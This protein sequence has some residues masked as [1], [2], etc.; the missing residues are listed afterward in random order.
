MFS[1]YDSF[2]GIERSST[3]LPKLGFIQTGFESEEKPR[4]NV[5]GEKNSSYSGINMPPN[6]PSRCWEW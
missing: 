6:V 3:S 1:Y 4:E 5:T 2:E